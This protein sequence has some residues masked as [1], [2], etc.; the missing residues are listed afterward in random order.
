MLYID[1]LLDYI[2]KRCELYFNLDY[3]CRHYLEIVIVF[4]GALKRCAFREWNLQLIQD[5]RPR[6]FLG[7]RML[8]NLA[9]TRSFVLHLSNLR[10]VTSIAIRIK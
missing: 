3:M 5:Y 8:S 7:Y 10:F 1:I 2:W 6:L 4:L 9:S